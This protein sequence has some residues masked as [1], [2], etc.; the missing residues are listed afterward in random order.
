MTTDNGTYQDPPPNA[1]YEGT[2]FDLLGQPSDETEEQLRRDLQAIRDA[3]RKAWLLART[4]HNDS[5]GT[6]DRG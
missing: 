3:E 4:T 1:D 2:I 6:P 5:Y